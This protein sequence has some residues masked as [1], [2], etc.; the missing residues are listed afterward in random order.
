MKTFPHQAWKNFNTEK[1]VWDRLVQGK[2]IGFHR[3][4]RLSRIRWVAWIARLKEVQKPHPLWP[5][6]WD[7][8]DYQSLAGQRKGKWWSACEKFAVPALLQPANFTMEKKEAQRVEFAVSQDEQS[9]QQRPFSFSI[10]LASTA[11]SSSGSLL[12]EFIST[13]PSSSRYSLLFTPT[14]TGTHLS[15]LT[16]GSHWNVFVVISSLQTSRYQL[17]NKKKNA[18]FSHNC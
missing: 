5:G 2:G 12:A 15:L 14:N 4:C 9:A 8:I 11:S 1:V 13:F 3:I 18:L 17:F 10:F 7:V 6:Q 16:L